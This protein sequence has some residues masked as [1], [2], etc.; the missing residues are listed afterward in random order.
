MRGD[1]CGFVLVSERLTAADTLTAP[2]SVTVVFGKGKCPA[3]KVV[4][5]VTVA[6]AGQPGI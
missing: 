3:V 5:R 1:R 2:R 4:Y 6:L